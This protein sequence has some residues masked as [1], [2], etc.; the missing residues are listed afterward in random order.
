MADTDKD[1]STL[2]FADGTKKTVEAVLDVADGV[3]LV[4]KDENSKIL[5]CNTNF[6]TLVG[7]TKAQITGSVDPRGEHVAH[8]RQVLDS[9][10]PLLN[11][12]ESIVDGSQIDVAIVTQK[13][14]VR[15]AQP[16]LQVKTTAIQPRGIGITVCFAKDDIKSVDYWKDRLSLRTNPLGGWWAPGTSRVLTPGEPPVYSTNYYMLFGMDV[17]QLHQLTQD[18]QWF[19][20][21]GHSIRLHIFYPVASDKYAIP[22]YETIL[23]GGDSGVLQCS[24]PG[25][26]WFGADLPDLGYSLSSCS[27]APGWTQA[28]TSNPQP[29]DVESLRAAF[30]DRPEEEILNRLL[31]RPQPNAPLL[32]TF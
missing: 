12:H 20:H 3:Y 5:W 19:F 16:Q 17:L 29:S 31:P 7:S 22:K 4:I 27:L 9:N 30:K 28:S 26:T 32:K 18:E 10:K 21:Y 25:G 1:N 8:D 24:V 15:T 23:V 6:A 14:I 11:L 2:Q 13:G